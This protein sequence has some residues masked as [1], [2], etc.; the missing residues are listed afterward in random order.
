VLG[1]QTTR[2]A[3]LVCPLTFTEIVVTPTGPA[4]V[5]RPLPPMAATEVLVEDNL[6]DI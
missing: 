6:P 5:A 3:V 2:T 4:L 1:S